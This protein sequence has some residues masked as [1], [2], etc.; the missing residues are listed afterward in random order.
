[1]YGAEAGCAT[2]AELREEAQ[3]EGNGSYL[4]F[5]ANDTPIWAQIQSPISVKVGNGT[6]WGRRMLCK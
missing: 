4:K 3:K 2:R 1:M 5:P 6:G